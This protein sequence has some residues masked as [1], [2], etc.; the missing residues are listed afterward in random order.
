MFVII[1]QKEEMHVAQNTY[2]KANSKT[3]IVAATGKNPTQKG[4]L[5]VFE[6]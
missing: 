3:K 5:R 2:K 1:P 4:N 6:E